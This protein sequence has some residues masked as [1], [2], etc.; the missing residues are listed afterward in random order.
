MMIYEAM[1]H[2]GDRQVKSE[3]G[4]RSRRD[5]QRE[6]RSIKDNAESTKIKRRSCPR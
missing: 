3:N 6:N 5:Y 1:N 2:H 4:Q